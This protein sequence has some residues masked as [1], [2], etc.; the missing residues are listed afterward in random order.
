[1]M[2]LSYNDIVTDYVN[3]NIVLLGAHH[4]YISNDSRTPL[5]QAL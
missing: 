1:M 3:A 4:G 2:C 5:G